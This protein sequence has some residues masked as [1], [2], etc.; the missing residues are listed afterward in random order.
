MDPRV[1]ASAA[2]IRQQYTLSRRLDAALRRVQPELAA[3]R[4]RGEAG[5]SRAQDLQRL[6]GTLTQLFGIVEGADVAP[7]TQAVAAIDEALAG[8]DRALAPR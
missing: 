6:S 1:K 2:D 8:V 5:A 3:A 4:S 7:T